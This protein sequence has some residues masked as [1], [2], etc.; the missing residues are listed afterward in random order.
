MYIISGKYKG[1]KIYTA[2]KGQHH[3][4]RPTKTS[5]REAIINLILNSSS[6]QD[7]IGNCLDLCCGNGAWGLEMLSLGAKFVTFIDKSYAAC[8]L[9][10]HNLIHLG[11]QH[12]QFNVIPQ[13]LVRN[14]NFFKLCQPQEVINKVK[15]SAETQTIQ[16]NNALDLMKQ[17]LLTHSSIS[18]LPMLYNFVYIDPPYEK[19]IDIV[20]KSIKPLSELLTPKGRMIVE[21]SYQSIL[22]AFTAFEVMLERRYGNTRITIY[23]KI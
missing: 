22:P 9:V 8:Q 13:D 6:A 2:L 15:L 23:Q 7:E 14:R 1:R 10:K 20:S 16:R 21:T 12:H 4:Y 18:T 19:A 17:E 11:I 5:V 3:D